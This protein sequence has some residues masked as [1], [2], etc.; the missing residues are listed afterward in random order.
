[1]MGRGVETSTNAGKNEEFLF[2]EANEGV[3]NICLKIKNYWVI[4]KLSSTYED[5]GTSLQTGIPIKW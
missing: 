5:S 2:L 3:S 4:L 1:M